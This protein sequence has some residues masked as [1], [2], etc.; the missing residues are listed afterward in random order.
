MRSFVLATKEFPERHTA[1]EIAQK[2]EEITT[3]FKVQD[4]VVC[5]VHDQASNMELAGTLLLEEQG[6]NTL[7]CT[8]HCLQLCLNAGFSIPAIDRLL[9]ASRKLVYHFHHSVV[10]TQALKTRQEQMNLP[11]NKLITACVTR[12][13]SNYDMLSRLLEMRW[14]VSAVLSDETVTKRSD[15]YLDLKTEH[16]TLAEEL[17]AVLQPFKVA[18]VFLQ[19]EHNS[20]LSCV[21][22]VI[23]GLSLSLN[24][25]TGDSSAMVTFKE[26]VKDELKTRFQLDCIDTSSSDVL[27]AAVDPRFRQ[28]KFLSDDDISAVKEE[29]VIFL[30]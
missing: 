2:L 9:G 21:L 29:L 10:A 26:T 24:P 27:A 11:Q 8:A 17:V 19:Y 18:T 25:L 12:W 4:K 6:W 22:P 7:K 14:P 28:L 13:N 30:R 16:W 5:V 20:S 3:D 15:R 23:H 1:I